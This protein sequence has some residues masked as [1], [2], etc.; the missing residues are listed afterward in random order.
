MVQ[1][2]EGYQ[3]NLLAS[4]MY[5][6]LETDL[7]PEPVI[8]SGIRQMLASKIKTESS[9]SLAAQQE[10]IAKF[11]AELKTM[12]IA[13]ETDAAN[14]QHYEVPTEFY[15]LVLGPRLKYSSALWKGST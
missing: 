12:P 1:K 10:K 7:V 13:I 11:V 4:I 6:I 8:R 5:K 14:E 3:M 15:K 2:E 9:P